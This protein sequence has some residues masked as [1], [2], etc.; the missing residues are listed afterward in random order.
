MSGEQ[1]ERYWQR[2]GQYGMPI[3]DSDVVPSFVGAEVYC[4]ERSQRQQPMP[5][6]VHLQVHA[7]PFT[8]SASMTAESARTLAAALV[9]AADDADTRIRATERPAP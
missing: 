5:F 1:A 4:A 2:H 3:N 8:F 9:S 6:H 7:V